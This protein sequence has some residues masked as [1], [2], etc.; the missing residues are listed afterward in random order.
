MAKKITND[1]SRRGFLGGTVVGAV[2]SVVITGSSAQAHEDRA[3]LN[4]IVNGKSKSFRP[5]ADASLAEALRDDLLLTGTKVGCGVGECGSCTVHMNGK[6]ARACT[7]PV[8][9]AD[10]ATILTIEGLESTDGKL[11]PL[12]DAFISE[13]ALQC[14]FCTPGQIMAGLACIQAG[15]AG[16][17]ASIASFMDG[18]ICRCGAHAQIVAAISAANGKMSNE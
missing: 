6:P 13:D 10:G 14:G 5:H 18:N 1:V 3:P 8:E 15:K 17:D 2:G 4:M 9:E 11:H 7:I 12:Q 16:S